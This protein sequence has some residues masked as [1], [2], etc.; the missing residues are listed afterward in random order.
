[1]VSVAG[2]LVGKRNDERLVRA[3]GYELDTAFS[4]IMV[5]FRY[6][7]RPGIV[8]IVGGLMGNAQVNIASMQVARLSE[9][10]EALM[11]MSVDSPIPEGVLDEIV[12]RARMR[13]ARLVV[14]GAAEL[15]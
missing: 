8:G 11:T 14:L 13:D 10:G 1:V 6:E 15:K 9:G 4:P 3:Y 12:A 2:V 5:L 7:D